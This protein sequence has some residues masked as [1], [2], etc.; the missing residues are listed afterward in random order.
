VYVTCGTQ[1]ARP[2]NWS[3]NYATERG[4]WTH[5]VVVC[6][7][8]RKIMRLIRDGKV[9]TT[10]TGFDANITAQDLYLNCNTAGTA[11]SAHY[12]DDLRIYDR[13]LTMDEALTLSRSLEKGTVGPVIPDN[14]DVSVS[15]GATLKVEGEG[16]A[17]KSLAGA[18]DLFLNGPTT[19]DPGAATNFTGTVRGTGTLKLASPVAATTVSANVEIS[20]GAELAGEA[21]PLVSTSGTLLVPASGSVTF[22]ARPTQKRYVIAE[23][24]SVAAA[25]GI[26]GWTTDLNREYWK[27]TF[28]L[29]G[30]AFVLNLKTSGVTIIV[31]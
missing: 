2:F 19:F 21:L 7:T 6:D 8:Q 11:N 15:A 5:I 24:T 17:V 28:S 29:E 3:Q 13:A 14:S 31:R 20:A 10:Y 16:H 4:C 30:G 23:G 12:I 26:A 25:D 9:E 1:S 18:G 27:S 22:A